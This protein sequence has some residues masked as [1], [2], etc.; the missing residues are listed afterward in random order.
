[1]VVVNAGTRC[2]LRPSHQSTYSTRVDDGLVPVVCS[3]QVASHVAK[4]GGKESKDD[5]GYE[6]KVSGGCY[7]SD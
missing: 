7:P 5:A 2:V 4:G 6:I 3:C 1:M